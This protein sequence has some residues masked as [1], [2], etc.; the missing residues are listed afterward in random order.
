[1]DKQLF[2]N[3]IKKPFSSVGNI[4]IEDDA[5]SLFLQDNFAYCLDKIKQQVMTQ[6]IK[7]Y[8]RLDYV[9]MSEIIGLHF[10]ITN[11]KHHGRFFHD[12][13]NKLVEDM[14][15]FNKGLFVIRNYYCGDGLGYLKIEDF[16]L[17]EILESGQVYHMMKDCKIDFNPEFLDCWCEFS[18]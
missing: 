4:Y 6:E 13:F 7:K 10:V 1:M 2:K 5:I 3:Q 15:L 8:P 9:S 12:F 11:H 16:E 18:Y 17:E 14:Y